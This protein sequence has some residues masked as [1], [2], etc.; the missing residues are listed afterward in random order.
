MT[1]YEETTW[2][3]I[4]KLAEWFPWG[5]TVSAIRDALVLPK[6]QPQG[7]LRSLQ[8]HGIVSYD[9]ESRTW[10]LKGSAG[11]ALVKMPGLDRKGVRMFSHGH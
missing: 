10:Y 5:L 2:Q 4:V 3:V 1:T 11:A 7:I 8:S 9:R 6:G